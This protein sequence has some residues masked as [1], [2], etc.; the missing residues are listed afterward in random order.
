MYSEPLPRPRANRGVNYSMFQL[1]LTRPKI[2]PNPPKTPGST[3]R[4]QS[5]CMYLEALCIVGSRNL[6]NRVSGSGVDTREKADLA[7]P[8]RSRAL[9]PDYGLGFGVRSLRFG[10]R[11]WVL[12]FGVW[13]LG[14]GV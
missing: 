13:G 8:E 7:L 6:R 12:R 14:F 11:V 1:K 4:I 10:G 3:G 2:S 9:P 5:H